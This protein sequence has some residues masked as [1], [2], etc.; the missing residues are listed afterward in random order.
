MTSSNALTGATRW[1][2]WP[3]MTEQLIPSVLQLCGEN[4]PP[5]V[6]FQVTEDT[7]AEGKHT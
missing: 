5:K 1:P 4:N 2:V 6:A 3:I 7:Q